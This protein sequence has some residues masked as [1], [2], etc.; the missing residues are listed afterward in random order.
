MKLT[1]LRKKP[2]RLPL[3]QEYQHYTEL[4]IFTWIGIGI[5]VTSVGII[6]WFIYAHVYQTIDRVDA[7]T[8]IQADPTLEPINFHLYNTI[9][10]AW[11]TKMTKTLTINTTTIRNPFITPLSAST[12]STPVIT[13]TQTTKTL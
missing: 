3:S 12:T 8:F 10:D 6:G 9:T 1:F 4:R 11:N 7:L 2:S 13:T 5:I